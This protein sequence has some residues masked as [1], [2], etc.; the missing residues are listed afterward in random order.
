VEM[1]VLQISVKEKPLPCVHCRLLSYGCWYS[2]VLRA[3]A[4][5]L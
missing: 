2:R 1:Y 3:S 5:S 4:A